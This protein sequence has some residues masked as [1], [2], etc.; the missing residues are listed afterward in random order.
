M[1]RTAIK[2]G[3]I[4]VVL[5]LLGA[6]LS[7]LALAG[8]GLTY[9]D[10]TSAMLAQQSDQVR[11]WGLFPLASLL[12]SGVGGWAKWLPSATPWRNASTIIC[13]LAMGRWLVGLLD[14]VS[15]RSEFCQF[16]PA[17]GS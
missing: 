17:N 4:I 15:R 8:A 3:V 11:F 5:G 14:P 7:F 2:T 12:L 10:P 16:V 9:P 1:Q 6:A 13:M